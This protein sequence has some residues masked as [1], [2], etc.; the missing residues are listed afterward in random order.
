MPRGLL[1]AKIETS[2]KFRTVLPLCRWLAAGVRYPFGGDIDGLFVLAMRR[3]LL[4]DR[5]YTMRSDFLRCLILAA[6]EV[7]Y[8]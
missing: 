4:N 6:I 5:N 3:V 8:E 2:K 7:S 1:R